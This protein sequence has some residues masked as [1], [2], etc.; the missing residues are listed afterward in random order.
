MIDGMNCQR[1]IASRMIGSKADYELAVRHNQGLLADSSET[2]F[3]C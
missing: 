3:C 2:P 1:E